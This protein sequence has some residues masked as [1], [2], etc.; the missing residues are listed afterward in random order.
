MIKKLKWAVVPI[1]AA[2]AFITLTSE[3]EEEEE[4]RKRILKTETCTYYT[5]EPRPGG[6]MQSVPHLGIQKY[7]R[8]TEES[9]HCSNGS[10]VACGPV[11]SN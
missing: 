6:G 3:T 9:S 10:Q 4:A 8:S 5:E 7:C 11:P 1:I 2:L